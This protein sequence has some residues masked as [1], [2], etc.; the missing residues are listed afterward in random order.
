MACFGR[1]VTSEVKISQ[2]WR[3]ILY[4]SGTF[5]SDL[6]MTPS[7]AGVQNQHGGESNR[8]PCNKTKMKSFSN[9]ILIF[10]FPL[11]RPAAAAA[12]C[13]SAQLPSVASTP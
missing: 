8:S 1:C 3:Q 5:P 9:F 7:M 11:L 10:I 12:P 4:Q 13:P 2:L 6:L